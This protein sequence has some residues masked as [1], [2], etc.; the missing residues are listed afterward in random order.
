MKNFNQLLQKS[1]LT[2]LY[3]RMKC[4]S[5]NTMNVAK[6][7]KYC[8][9]SPLAIFTTNTDKPSLFIAW[10]ELKNLLYSSIYFEVYLV[11]TAYS[12]TLCFML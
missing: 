9:G 8:I 1:S 10:E 5:N 4:I 3:K 2:V 12:L 11:H 6:I 7:E